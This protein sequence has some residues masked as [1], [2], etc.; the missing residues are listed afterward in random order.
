MLTVSIKHEFSKCLSPPFSRLILFSLTSRAGVKGCWQKPTGELKPPLYP[1]VGV[2]LFPFLKV[3][4]HKEVQSEAC[5]DWV[6]HAFKDCPATTQASSPCLLRKCCTG[7]QKSFWVPGRVGQVLVTQRLTHP[8]RESNGE[9]VHQ[10]GRSVNAATF[11]TEVDWRQE[12]GAVGELEFWSHHLLLARVS[13]S[14]K[15]MGSRVDWRELWPFWDGIQVSQSTAQKVI[16]QSELQ[17]VSGP[18]YPVNEEW[19]VF[20]MKWTVSVYFTYAKDKSCF[21][22]FSLQYTYMIYTG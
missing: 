19:I 20:L 2:F 4:S 5:L 12:L 7:T 3:T 11:R 8:K 1:R 17:S 9:A 10:L 16:F 22:E 18:S 14:G 15:L 13:F 21:L 6:Y